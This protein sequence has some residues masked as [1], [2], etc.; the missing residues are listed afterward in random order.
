M[1]QRTPSHQV[2]SD[3]SVVVTA[4]RRSAENASSWTTS[5]QAGK[6]RSRPFATTA[7]PTR[8]KDAGVALEVRLVAADEVLQVPS[9]HGWSGATWFGT[10]SRISPR[11]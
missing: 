10:K 5:G 3:R 9:S 11:P 4:P 7:S 1:S 8:T 2:A 6:Y